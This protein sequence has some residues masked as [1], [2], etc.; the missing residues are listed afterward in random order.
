[1]IRTWLFL[2]ISAFVLKQDGSRFSITS[3]THF[4]R[5]THKLYHNCHL[6]FSSMLVFPA[7]FVCTFAVRLL[8]THSK[9]DQ[10]CSME[11]PIQKLDWFDPNNCPLRFLINRNNKDQWNCQNILGLA[12][13]NVVCVKSVNSASLVAVLIWSLLSVL[14]CT[15]AVF[16]W[17]IHKAF[18]VIFF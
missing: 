12:Q 8:Q 18:V 13:M 4:T 6:Y 14:T 7:C 15:I 9:S 10:R 5:L 11:E 1:M 3:L 17:L 2:P 16:L